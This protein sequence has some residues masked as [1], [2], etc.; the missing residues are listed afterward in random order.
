MGIQGLLP[1]LAP[2]TTDF[3]VS[4]LRGKRVA[5]DAYVWL[6]RGTYSKAQTLALHPDDAHAIASVVRYVMTLVGM[7]KHHGAAAFRTAAFRTGLTP[8]LPIFA[9]TA[10]PRH[11][12][13][14]KNR[15]RAA[16]RVRRVAAAR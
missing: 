13:T 3:H 15:R 7:L 11:A 14:R 2:I 12:Y 8:I 1:A 10:R 5:V 9:P 4:A 16:A 6:H